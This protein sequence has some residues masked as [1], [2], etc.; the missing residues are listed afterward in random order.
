[1]WGPSG[2]GKTALLRAIA[3]L[4]APQKGTV[5][6]GGVVVS[7]AGRVLV[8]AQ[9]RDL[10]MVFHDLALWPH[11]TVRE[12]LELAARAGV[13][14]PEERRQ[15]VE[16]MLERMDLVE[17]GAARPQAL[18]ARERFRL[19]VGR[20]LVGTPRA[21]L[22]D[23]PLAGLEPGLQRELLGTLR[24]LLQERGTAALYATR[25][26]RAAVSL[27]DRLAVLEAGRVVQTGKLDELRNAPST[28]LVERFFEDL[29]WTGGGSQQAATEDD[30]F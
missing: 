10:G 26:P 2:S 20:A 19:A 3:G 5:G 6:V 8:P 13:P 11:L 14:A 18:G 23:D 24:E 9:D 16:R 7:A 1:V 22:L 17:Q 15:R 25:D 30:R 4:E 12:N 27:G 21:V 29:K 28:E